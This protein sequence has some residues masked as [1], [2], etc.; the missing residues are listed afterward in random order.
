MMTHG[1]KQDTDQDLAHTLA[2]FTHLLGKSIQ[3][4]KQ[5]EAG[6]ARCYHPTAPLRVYILRFQFSHIPDASTYKH[7]NQMLEPLEASG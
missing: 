6:L 4:R 3:D 2:L 1:Q 5:K 7:L